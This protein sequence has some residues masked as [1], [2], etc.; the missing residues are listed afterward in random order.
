MSNGKKW[1]ITL[2]L[3]FIGGAGTAAIDSAATPKDIIRHGLVAMGPV[4]IALKTRLAT[5][6]EQHPKQFTA[7]GG[8]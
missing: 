6:E 8:K 3:G 4:A 5:A 7:A 2:A 1:L